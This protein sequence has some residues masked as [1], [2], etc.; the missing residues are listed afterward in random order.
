MG[1]PHRVLG[2]L[3]TDGHRR[4]AGELFRLRERI[5]SV[6][7][8]VTMR[9]KYSIAVLL[10]LV[11]TAAGCKDNDKPATQQAPAAGTEA[12]AAEGGE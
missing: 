11:G 5:P 9:G 7:E 8:G 10:L 6:E 1:V 3:R 2:V 12:D 4:F